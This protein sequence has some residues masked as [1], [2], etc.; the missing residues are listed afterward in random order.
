[1]TEHPPK[2]RI[3]VDEHGPYLVYGSPPLRIE[4]ITTDA[5]GKSRSYQ[6][7][8]EIPTKDPAVLCR[9]GQSA[10]KPFCDNSHKTADVNLEETASFEFLEAGA[11]RIDGVDMILT[12]NEAYCAY[13]RFC[14][15]DQTVWGE[16][17]I[18]GAEHEATAKAMVRNCPG[19]RLELWDKVSGDSLEEPLEPA[20]FL[21][22]D[23]ALG[24]L[25]GP[26]RV[27]GNIPVVSASGRTYQVRNRQALCRC[28]ASSNKPFCDGS[29]ASVG[30][31]DGLQAGPMSADGPS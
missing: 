13:A 16:V 21:V 28:G 26:L 20:V 17:A 11:E 5:D 23:P 29:H 1:M 9:C 22:E 27:T 2:I 19:G 18:P 15:A 12:D 24:G 31:T 4:T 10:N 25:S 6:T 14:D 8:R 30:F 3:V 7:G